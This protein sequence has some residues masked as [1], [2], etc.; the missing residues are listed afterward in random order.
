MDEPAISP[1]RVGTEIQAVALGGLNPDP[2]WRRPILAQHHLLILITAGHGTAQLDFRDHSCHPG[3]VL[4]VRPGQALRCVGAGLDGFGVRWTGDVPDD[5][6]GGPAALPGG[7]A[8]WQPGGADGDAMV[9]GITQLVADCGRYPEDVHGHLLARHQLAAVLLRLA[10]LSGRERSGGVAEL[11]TFRRLWAEVER[12]HPET[13]RVEDYATTLGCSVRT[14]TR[15][16]LAVTGHSAKQVID[17]RV[18]LAAMRLL[19]AT[20][21]P[22]AA[23]GRRLGFPEPTN[24]GRFF[25]REVGL[26]PGA[27]RAGRRGSAGSGT[28][29]LVGSAS[30]A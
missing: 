22:I 24:F 5:P 12:R 21:E 4:R 27:F 1:S 19:V 18:A 8:H 20:D 2:S 29:A 9:A 26:S 28:R 6:D 15:A 7:A 17:Q 23:V 13:R 11:A 16:C 14:L 10:L 3:V 30:P 25:V